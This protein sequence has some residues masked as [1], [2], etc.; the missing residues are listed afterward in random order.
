VRE[1]EGMS[2][3]PIPLGTFTK[4]WHLLPRL[5]TSRLHGV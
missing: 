2:H 1:W 4:K 3:T 5:R